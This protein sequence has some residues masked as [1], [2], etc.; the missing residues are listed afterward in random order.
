MMNNETNKTSLN[1][2]VPTLLAMIL[3]FSMYLATDIKQCKNQEIIIK[4][5]Q[6]IISEISEI[7][8]ENDEINNIVEPIVE[9]PL[10]KACLIEVPEQVFEIQLEIPDCDTSF[11]SYMDYNCITDD[12]TKQWELQQTAYT[13]EYGLRKVGTDYCVAVGS[14]YSE[15]VGERFKIILDNGNEF[16]VIISDLKQDKHTDSSN[17]YSPVYDENGN[18]YSAN[19]LE[20]IVDVDQLHSMVTTLG[21]VSYYDE[22]EGNIVSIEKI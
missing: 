10:V 17:R 18:F 11:K 7:K 1:G 14:Y 13:D 21:T 3:V 12:T 8:T 2:I 9:P 6:T 16:T 19:V 15:T 5:Q 22:F 20:F 4:N